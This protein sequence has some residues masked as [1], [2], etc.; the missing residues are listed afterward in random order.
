MGE[1]P[2]EGDKVPDFRLP[3]TD[4]GEISLADLRGKDVILYFYVRDNTPGCTK[5][6]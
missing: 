6:A 3:S 4:G 2:R 5:Q 1:R